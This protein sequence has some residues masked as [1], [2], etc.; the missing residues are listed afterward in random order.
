[1][2]Q[3]CSVD[4]IGVKAFAADVAMRMALSSQ[5]SALSLAALADRHCAMACIAK[6]PPGAK[7][8]PKSG[9]AR[10]AQSQAV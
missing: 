2:T 9:F 5:S 4:V 7:G 3:C 10:C 6:L 1:M 8:A